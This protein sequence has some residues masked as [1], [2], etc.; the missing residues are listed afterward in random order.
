MA[1]REHER[2]RLRLEEQDPKLYYDYESA[3]IRQKMERDRVHLLPRIVKPHMFAPGGHPLGDLRVFERY[4]NAPLSCLT[5]AFLELQTGEHT[6][7]QRRIPSL[8]AYVMEGSGECLQDDQTYPFSAGDLVVIPPYTTYQFRA[9]GTS[10][11]AWIPEVR[12]W[13]VLGLLWQE[14]LEFQTI[15]EGAEPLTQADGEVAGLR[16]PPGVLGLEQELLVRAG[17]DPHR[18]SV[19]AARRSAQA[20][21]IGNTKYDHFL[22][23]LQEEND[24]EQHGPRVIRAEDV[25]WEDTRQ[26]RL[27]FYVSAWTETPARALDVMAQEIEPGGHSGKHRHI[28]EEML[29]VFAGSGYDVHEDQRYAWS[30]GD[31]ICIPPMTAHQHHADAEGARLISVWPRQLAHEFLGGIEHISDASSWHPSTT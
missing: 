17:T 1:E 5:C 30:A 10:V 18:E 29:L 22:R 26:G 28:F 21:P 23:R 12:L 11:R 3:F 16:V 20:G 8:V 19:F 25:P 31:L 14:Q 2:E 27:K 9:Q 7:L 4:R 15:P 24:L 6:D 13:H